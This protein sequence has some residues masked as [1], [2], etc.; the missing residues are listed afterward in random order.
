MKTRALVFELALFVVGA[1]VC[2]SQNVQMGTWKLNEA[3][4]KLSPGAPKNNTVEYEVVG[5]NVKVTI[6]GVGG[7]GKLSIQNGQVS[8]TA[9]TIP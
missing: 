6:D 3:K 4:S 8:L 9:K 1:V 2:F 7:D 5:Q